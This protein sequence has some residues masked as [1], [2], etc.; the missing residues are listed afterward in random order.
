MG[1]TVRH[2]AQVANQ[3]LYPVKHA[4]E[5]CSQAVELVVGAPDRHALGHLAMH[6]LLRCAHNI[7]D[8][9]IDQTRQH[10]RRRL[11]ARRVLEDHPHTIDFELLD[12]VLDN[13]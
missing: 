10:L 1:N 6:D 2:H 12:V 5:R 3:G 13:A 9:A 11:G 8:A 4:I 7:A